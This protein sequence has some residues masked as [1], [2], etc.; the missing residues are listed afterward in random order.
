[1]HRYA[2]R[3]PGV[4][5][6][7][8]LAGL[9]ISWVLIWPPAF[10]S[11]AQ[12]LLQSDQRQFNTYNELRESLDGR[13]IIAIVI[14]RIDVF[15]DAGAQRLD[16]ITRA[17]QSIEGMTN[18]T[19]LTTP[20]RPL[21]QGMKLVRAPFIPIEGATPDQWEQIKQQ[22]TGNLIARNV[23]VS[24]QGD[25][26]MV[27]AVSGRQLAAG[28]DRQRLRD[29]LLNA[30]EPFD[31]V[32]VISYSVIDGEMRQTARRDALRFVP[33]AIIVTIGVLLITFRR[34][35]LV[36]AMLANQLIV[37]LTLPVLLS[38]HAALAGVM[39]GHDQP[40]GFDLYT[41]M[42][43]PLTAAIHLA[44]QVHV[45][46]A[47]L[48]SA[49]P[50]IDQRIQQGVKQVT[51]PTLVAAATTVVGLL[52]LAFSEVQ[53][54]VRFA[55]VGAAAVVVAAIYTLGPGMALI[56]LALGERTIP[57]P[58]RDDRPS[59]PQPRAGGLLGWGI[60]VALLLGALIPGVVMIRTDVRAI[61]MLN[62]QSMTR[63]AAELIDR[64]FGG[65]NLFMVEITVADDNAPGR[66]PINDPQ[67]LRFMRDKRQAVARIAGVGDAYDYSQ[68]FSMVNRIWH[69]DDPAYDRLPDSA[70]GHA[71]TSGL[72]ETF[73]LPFIEKLRLDDGRTAF[74]L[75]R[76]ASMPSR[77]YL[78]LLEQVMATVERD[79]PPGITVRPR[80]GLHNILQ[81]DRQLVAEQ[82]RSGGI[83]LLAVFVI[84][85]L[86]WRSF[87]MGLAATVVSALPVLAM[88]GLAGY[89]DTSINSITMMTASVVLGLVVD[90]AAHLLDMA[91]RRRRE[92]RAWP[93]A[94]AGA[95]VAKRRPIICTSL[96]LGS[97]LGLFGLSA[98]PPVRAFGLL[99]CAALAAA[100]AAVLVLLPAMMLA[101][102]RWRA[103]RAADQSS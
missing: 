4:T 31:D 78:H 96:V 37:L 69:G 53:P 61:E 21:R 55:I 68:A 74:I 80:T 3:H 85:A 41:S 100:L 25:A 15:T 38:I 51:R 12:V 64:K 8:C 22:V 66:M 82:K 89:T 27:L 46:A 1:V 93:D 32:Y 77:D 10:N 91:A 52:S 43:L 57:Q 54:V 67:L 34:P 30:I 42:L 65:A 97:I 29:D 14:D 72:L 92:G 40:P 35:K 24:P 9:A 5:I 20:D 47:C 86:A 62:Q 63:R 70:L 19:S 99:S 83:T 58:S 48:R 75:L 76:T 73:Q 26:A 49:A 84:V 28:E 90:D 17:V 102:A 95:L 56:G 60:A 44:L 59:Q 98:F 88:L 16:R 103:D 23:M 36:A 81:Q 71:I 18:V 6:G 13:A 7:L 33:A 79:V 39:S 101:A 2:V 94:I 50:T 87:W 11:S 45:T